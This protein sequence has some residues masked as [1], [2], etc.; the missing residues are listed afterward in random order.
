MP[1]RKQHIVET[2]LY[3]SVATL[4]LNRRLLQAVEAKLRACGW[5]LPEARWAAVFGTV[6]SALLDVMLLPA[7]IPKT[8]ARSVE[9]IMPHEAPDPDRNRLFLLQPVASAAGA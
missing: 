1:S 7:R 5:R 8:L 3:A 4:Q 2:L 9:R 6:A